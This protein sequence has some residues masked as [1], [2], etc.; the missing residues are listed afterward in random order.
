MPNYF[1]LVKNT[2]TFTN[3]VQNWHNYRALQETSSVPIALLIARS[4]YKYMLFLKISLQNK[5]Y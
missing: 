3:S 4:N 1:F 5:K 2:M